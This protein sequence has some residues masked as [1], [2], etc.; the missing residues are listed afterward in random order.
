MDEIIPNRLKT[1]AHIVGFILLPV[2]LVLLDFSWDTTVAAGE[3]GEWFRTDIFMEFRLPRVIGSCL[4]GLLLSWSGLMMQTLFRNPLAGPFLIGITPG[5]S[6]GIAV[7]TFLGYSIFPDTVNWTVPTL[8]IA[9]LMG[10]GVVMLIQWQLYRFW[11]DIHSLLLAGLILGYFFGAAVDIL[12]QWGEARQLKFFVMWN[13]GSFDRLQATQL[14]PMGVAAITGG[15]ILYAGRYKFNNY[16]L[17]DI[18]VQSSG[19]SLAGIRA[20]LIA[21]AAVMAALCT[22]YC[23]PISFVGI[24]A[25]HAA[26]K[27]IG[28]DAHEKTMWHTA[29]AGISFTVGADFISHYA[30]ANYSLPLNAVL[31]LAGAPIVFLILFRGNR[32]P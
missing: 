15:C 12:Q 31:S 3:W 2:G 22:A 9:A 19:S 24:L 1:I 30:I 16:L 5:A 28:S 26:R 6:F 20:A 27:L 13:M 10:A 7:I 18:Y 25:P 29:S 11:R 8:P 23:G 17:G 32:N 4:A 21:G 14:W